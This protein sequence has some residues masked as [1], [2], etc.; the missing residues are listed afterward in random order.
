[1]DKN[2]DAQVSNNSDAGRY[3]ISLDGKPAGFAEYRLKDS[4][5]IFTHTEVDSAFEGRGAGS[6]LARYALDDVRSRGLQAAPLCP[7]IAAYIE[8]HPEYQDLVATD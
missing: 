2:E 8:R 4:R 1:M 6:T 7:F 3:E 5:V